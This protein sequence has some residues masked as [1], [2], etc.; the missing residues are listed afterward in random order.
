LLLAAGC[1]VTGIV[2][3]VGL[4][5]IGERTAIPGRDGG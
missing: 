1:A 5:A 2:L 4:T 3:V